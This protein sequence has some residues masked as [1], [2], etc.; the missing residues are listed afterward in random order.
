MKPITIMSGALAAWSAFA[1][2]TGAYAQ[3]G[4]SLPL[5]E[6]LEIAKAY[7]NLTTQI[8][9]TLVGANLKAAQVVCTGARFPNTWAELGGARHAPYECDI[10][11]RKLTITATPTYYDKNGHKLSASD[12][13][14]PTKA[15]K[16]K[17]TQ[18]KWKWK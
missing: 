5:T 1:S 4:G 18:L 7:P 10:A 11:S 15:A 16:L 3:Q 9:L 6:V 13:T 2:V 17:E 12:K 8:R 14:L